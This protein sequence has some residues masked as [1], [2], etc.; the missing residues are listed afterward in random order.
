M[1]KQFNFNYL[2]TT[3]S[4]TVSYKGQHYMVTKTSEPLRYEQ[5]KT[6]IKNVDESAFLDALIPKVKVIKY[7][8]EYF[9]MDDDGN[10]YMKDEPNRPIAKVIAKKLV[11]FAKSDLPIEPIV[12]FWK[13]LRK[14]PSKNSQ[15]MLY[16]FLEVNHHP[17]TS[18]GNFIAYKKVDRAGNKLV[19]NYTKKIDNTPGKI[20]EMPRKD[21]V[22]DKNI[23]CTKGLHVAAW[24]YAK[25][26]SGNVLIEVMVDPTDVV[27]VPTDYNSQK[28]RV[29]RY[30][31]VCEIGATVAYTDT[32]KSD[33]DEKGMK[34]NTDVKSAVSE[35]GKNVSFVAMTAKE[36]IDVVTKLAG[37][38]EASAIANMSL[39]NKQPI[40][41]KAVAILQ[42]KGY[43]V[44]TEQPKTRG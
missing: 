19:D 22:E 16:S 44:V 26:Y 23:T 36:I 11:E 6:A 21:V 27:S 34:H 5:L 37:K 17:I 9:E 43:K 18:E 14:N 12:Y 41:K 24:D 42:A 32:L 3:N 15:E 4:V 10:V 30:K 38:K 25:T 31:V 2:I 29:C 8:T 33:R 39:K 35:N 13:K 40:V 7:S 20:V 28:M 1:A